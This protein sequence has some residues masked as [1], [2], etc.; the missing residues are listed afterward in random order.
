LRLIFC[1]KSNRVDQVRRAAG[2]AF[3]DLG[4]AL[5]DFARLNE[6]IRDV[7]VNFWQL[8]V[9]PN[10]ETMSEVQTA[11]ILGPA[12][13]NIQRNVMRSANPSV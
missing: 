8:M 4:M 13:K 7:P 1:I 5:S 9:K 10:V 3:L 12:P 6:R 2:G 11:S